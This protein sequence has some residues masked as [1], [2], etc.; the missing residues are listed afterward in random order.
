MDMTLDELKTLQPLQMPSSKLGNGLYQV[1][2]DIEREQR[3]VDAEIKY[4]DWFT[5]PVC[6]YLFIVRT[7]SQV[8]DFWVCRNW[9]R[10][11]LRDCILFNSSRNPATKASQTSLGQATG[12]GSRSEYMSTHLQPS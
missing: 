6:L 9:M 7:R 5:T 11:Q 3:S 8:V 4:L 12:L 10:K 2:C 1:K